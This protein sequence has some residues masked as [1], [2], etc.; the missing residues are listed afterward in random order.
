MKVQI[1]LDPHSPSMFRVN[2]P[3]SNRK[4]F[5]EDFKCEENALMNAKP[6]CEVW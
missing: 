6:K 5:L 4:E 1:T 3:F 2:V